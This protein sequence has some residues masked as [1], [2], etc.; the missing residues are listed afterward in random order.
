MS[1][2]SVLDEVDKERQRQDVKW[3]GPCHDDRHSTTDFVHLIEDYACVA[4]TMASINNHDE[5]RE[6]LVRVAALAVAAVERLDRL[7]HTPVSLFG[8]LDG[9][10]STGL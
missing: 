2:E 4:Q 7:K 5:A 1:T 6:L 8:N 9:R 3:G 10:P